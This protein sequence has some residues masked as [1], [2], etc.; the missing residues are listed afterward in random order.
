[1]ASDVYQLTINEVISRDCSANWQQAIGIVNAEFSD[2]SLGLYLRFG[3]F[4]ALWFVYI[5]RFAGTCTKTNSK[6]AITIFVA[7]TNHLAAFQRQNGYG[8]MAAIFVEEAHHTHLFR[9]HASAH[10]LHSIYN[11]EAHSALLPS[12]RVF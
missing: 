10:D 11:T 8:N 1:V 9:D 3:E 7:G 6:I 12:G 2:A 4:A 5:F